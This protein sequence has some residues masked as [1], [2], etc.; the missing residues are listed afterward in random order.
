MSDKKNIDWRDLLIN[1]AF[2]LLMVILGITIAFQLDNWKS[3]AERHSQEKFYSERIL[4]DI[5]L[6]IEE[7]TEN[8]QELKADRVAVENYMSRMNELPADSLIKPVMA[9]LSFE[10]FNGNQNTYQTL[11]AG[12]RLNTFSDAT[13]VEKLTGYYSSYTAIRRLETV[14][15]TALFEIHK[16]FSPYMIY[17][18]GKIVDQGVVSLP[19]TRNSLLIANEQLNNGVEDYGYALER[20]LALKQALEKGL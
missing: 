15:T 6:D 17:D 10:T 3:D 11:V 4:A 8:L 12:A 19:A 16:Q 13:V 9:I 5:N 18:K 2:D 7:L 14:Y 20:A 1:K